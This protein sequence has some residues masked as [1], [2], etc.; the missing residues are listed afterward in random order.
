MTAATGRNRQHVRVRRVSNKCGIPNGPSKKP[1]TRWSRV[2]W[3]GAKGIRTP[4]QGGYDQN[5][6]VVGV[7]GGVTVVRA[8]VKTV[9]DLTDPARVGCDEPNPP[10]LGPQCGNRHDMDPVGSFPAAAS[11][12]HDSESRRPAM[13]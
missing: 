4:D 2:F 5:R 9:V 1:E 3:S 10:S 12:C 13:L 7:A 6:A 11:R 8:V